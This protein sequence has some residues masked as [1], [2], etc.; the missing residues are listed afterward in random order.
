MHFGQFT[1]FFMRNQFFFDFHPPLGK[2]LFALTGNKELT[3]SA[4]KEILVAW[5]YLEINVTIDLLKKKRLFSILLLIY[6]N[7]LLPGY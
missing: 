7:N 1:N 4:K 5:K 3:K 6:L 2:L